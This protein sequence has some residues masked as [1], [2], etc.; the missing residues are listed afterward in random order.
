MTND[1]YAPKIDSDGADPTDYYRVTFLNHSSVLIETKKHIVLTDPFWDTP[2]FETWL[3]SP[4]SYIHPVYLLAI[5]K[6][7][8][9]R[10]SILI[11][12][13]HDDHCDNRLLSLFSQ[14]NIIITKFSSPGLRKRIESIGFAN[15]TEI[16]EKEITIE[17]LTFNAFIDKDFSHDDSIQIIRNEHFRFIHANDCWWKLKPEYIHAIGK[18]ES[19]D[20]IY[21][22]QI[23]IADAFPNAYSCFN[24]DEK[25][26]ISQTRVSKH[27]IS[28]I[29]NANELGAS[30]FLHYA[31]HVKIFANQQ[32]INSSGFIENKFIESMIE[33]SNLESKTKILDM[34]PGDSY[35]D[36]K[37]SYSLLRNL[38]SEQHL[39]GAS[40]DYWEEY[41]NFYRLKGETILSDSELAKSLDMFMQSFKDY[42]VNSVER[43]NFRTEILKSRLIINIDESLQAEIRFPNFK[44]IDRIDLQIY[45]PRLIAEKILTGGINFEASYIG[46]LGHFSLNPKSLYNGHVIRWLSMFGYIWQ[47]SQLN[48]IS[49]KE[50]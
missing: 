42:V 12:H 18:A 41:G 35:S 27:L 38:Y 28:A 40:V 21:A 45:W 50:V 39:K 25:R 6:T 36:Y 4:P 5:A 43:K 26:Q 24:E 32:T 33:E 10:F 2:A 15:I 34:L 49:S 3:P 11:S 47:K 29:Q 13:G 9:K 23:A 48:K 31:G 30:G 20:T 17:G 8:K 44:E 46:C 37:V 7:R 1:I 16:D 19:L 14:F 22:S